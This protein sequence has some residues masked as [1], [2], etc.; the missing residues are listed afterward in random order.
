[1][2]HYGVFFVDEGLWQKHEAE[3][4]LHRFCLLL[5]EFP[6]VLG[7]YSCGMYGI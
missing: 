2:E 6:L 4:H 3:Y 1:M 7:G 5:I